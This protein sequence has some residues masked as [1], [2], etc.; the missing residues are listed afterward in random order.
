[1]C[2]TQAETGQK[3]IVNE[4]GLRE[5]DE[6][7]EEEISWFGKERTRTGRQLRCQE[8]AGEAFVL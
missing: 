2:E 5:G 8:G 7:P 6:K 3:G 4:L 1:M